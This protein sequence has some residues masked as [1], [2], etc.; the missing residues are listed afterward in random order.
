MIAPPPSAPRRQAG[1]TDTYLVGAAIKLYPELEQVSSS[2]IPQG[3]QREN[4]GAGAA[5]GGT[6]GAERRAA[7][8][9]EGDRLH[10][11]RTAKKQVKKEKQAQ[12][13]A[14]STQAAV[15]A[16]VSEIAPLLQQQSSDNTWRQKTDEADSR[17]AAITLSQD[18]LSAH[19]KFTKELAAEDALG[20]AGNN[21][22]KMYISKQIA[23][24]EK[25]M[26]EGQ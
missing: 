5:T 13:V 7:A 16:A 21:A 15:K 14:E 8:K 22:R 3:A 6:G 26:N 18:I 11:D 25:A 12:G 19:Q 10:V 2:L 9:R 17:S 23:S 24:L 1:D 20:S 4:N